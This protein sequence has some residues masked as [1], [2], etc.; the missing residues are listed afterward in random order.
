M[1]Y[2]NKTYVCFDADTDIRFYR[3]MQA[4]KQN[5]NTDFDF[6][7]AH[8]LYRILPTS[9]EET[10]K[11]NLR[12]RLKNSKVF[13]LLVG[14]Q[15]RYLYRFVRWEIEQALNFG[16]S[17]IVVNLNGRRSMD[18]ERIPP[19]LREE[20]AIHI[21]F[22]A[23]IMQHALENWESQ[24]HDL[25]LSDKTGPYYYEDMIYKKLGL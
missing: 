24:S 12:E 16:L 22:N 25:K 6:Y 2:R 11:H 19:L 17:I 13:V 23:G 3:L 9:S 7:N 8:D 10:I 20:L 5:D 18:S 14:E 4:W 1:A 21:S 15:T